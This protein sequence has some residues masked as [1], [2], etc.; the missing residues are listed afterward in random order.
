MESGHPEI[1]SLGDAVLVLL[2][3]NLAVVGYLMDILVEVVVE[4][5]LVML[6]LSHY[7]IFLP[8]LLGFSELFAADNYSAVNDTCILVIGFG[9]HLMV[10]GVVGDVVDDLLILVSVFVLVWV[11]EHIF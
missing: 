6:L 3:F 4:C 9:V 8:F 11:S 2:P 10:P 1:A 5:C 7:V